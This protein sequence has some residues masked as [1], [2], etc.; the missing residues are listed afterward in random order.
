MIPAIQ[1]A[2]IATT[3]VE[4]SPEAYIARLHDIGISAW[5]LETTR[6]HTPKV[7]YTDSSRQYLIDSPAGLIAQA[8]QLAERS[9]TSICIIE[10][11][12]PEWVASL[13]AAWNIDPDVFETHAGNGYQEDLWLPHLD[14]D[15][16]PRSTSERARPSFLGRPIEYVEG[17][18]EYHT[19]L[20]TLPT[21][22]VDRSAVDPI[23]GEPVVGGMINVV[24]PNHVRRLCFKDGK[25]PL[26]SNT[27]ITYCRPIVGMCKSSSPRLHS[28]SS[29]E[30]QL[31]HRVCLLHFES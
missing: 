10:N 2:K 9:A 17:I 26:Q 4:D 27:R 21:L 24:P 8:A 22:E 3:S 23:I 28:H 29:Y 5:S 30:E 15:W 25:W 14:L 16:N 11:I 13:G 7:F 19:A 12:S 6:H 20:S 18:F 1:L 31:F